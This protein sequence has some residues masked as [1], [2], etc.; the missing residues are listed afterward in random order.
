VTLDYTKLEEYNLRPG[1]RRTKPTT[2][3]PQGHTAPEDARCQ[4]K[5]IE[6][7]NEGMDF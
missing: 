4:P 2:P 5:T 3:R 7:E 6:L 1:P